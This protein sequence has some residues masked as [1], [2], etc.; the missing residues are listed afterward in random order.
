MEEKAR[1]YFW[2]SELVDLADEK[3]NTEILQRGQ[4][5]CQRRDWKKLEEIIEEAFQEWLQHGS[6]P[7]YA[8]TLIAL[9]DTALFAGALGLARRCYERA[10]KVLERRIPPVQRQNE[11]VT[12]YGQ[13]LINVLMLEYQSAQNRLAL[14][15]ELMLEP[16]LYWRR[17]AK[18]ERVQKCAEIRQFFCDFSQR[19][20]ALKGCSSY[21]PTAERTFSFPFDFIQYEELRPVCTGDADVDFEYSDSDLCYPS[22]ARRQNGLYLMWDIPRLKRIVLGSEDLDPRSF[23]PRIKWI[24]LGGEDPSED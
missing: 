23:G 10:G 14:A 13:A 17:L 1:Q 6:W 19:L 2:P 16:E 7:R 21:T 11:A 22:F 5:A 12:H 15:Q 3:G 24:I 8:L 20:E 18:R 4:E 9:A